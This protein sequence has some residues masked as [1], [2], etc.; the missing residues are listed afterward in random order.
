MCPERT[1]DFMAHPTRFERVTFAFGVLRLEACQPGVRLIS[2]TLGARQ[3]VTD[4]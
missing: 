4:P 3:L 1:T 2:I